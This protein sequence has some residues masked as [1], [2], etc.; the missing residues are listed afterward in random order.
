MNIYSDC[1]A[2]TCLLIHCRHIQAA[3]IVRGKYDLHLRYA[4]SGGPDPRQCKLS[5]KFVFHRDQAL[6][7]KHFN[8][9]VLLVVRDCAANLFGTKWNW[10]SLFHHYCEALFRVS[11]TQRMCRLLDDLDSLTGHQ[12]SSRKSLLLSQWLHPH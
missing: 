2:D 8:L 10:G 7:L 9:H 3:H 5:K 11:H 12:N 1:I 4:S 6:P